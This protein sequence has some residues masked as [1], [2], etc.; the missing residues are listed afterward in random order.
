MAESQRPSSTSIAQVV[1][2]TLTY[3]RIKAIADDLGCTHE[4]VIRRAM[5]VFVTAWTVGKGHRV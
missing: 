2:D 5:E 1:V 3:Q 4:E